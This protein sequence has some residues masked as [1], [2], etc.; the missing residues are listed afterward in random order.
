MSRFT[1][2]DGSTTGS[3][4]EW[5]QQTVPIAQQE[6]PCSTRLFIG[7]YSRKGGALGTGELMTQN[8]TSSAIMG[9]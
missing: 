5:G 9:C 1:A 7:K 3:C 2:E 4:G 6:L 8:L